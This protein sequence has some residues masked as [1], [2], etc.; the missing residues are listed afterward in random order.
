VR[1]IRNRH[2]MQGA[3]APIPA[4]STLSNSSVPASL[5]RDS[6]T[7][8]KLTPL[9]ASNRVPPA[10]GRVADTSLATQPPA[11]GAAAAATKSWGRFNARGGMGPVPHYHPELC[12]ARII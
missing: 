12:L 1:A 9:Q 2:A 10:V 3:H 6:R 11:N 8:S 7:H 5:T 4:A